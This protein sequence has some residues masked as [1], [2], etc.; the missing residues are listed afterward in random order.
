MGRLNT[1]EKKIILEVLI[2]LNTCYNI[3]MVI[4]EIIN[5]ILT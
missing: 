2:S 4:I 3:K 5:A 1:S